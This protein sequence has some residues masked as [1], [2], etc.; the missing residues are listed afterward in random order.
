MTTSIL[1]FASHNMLLSSLAAS[2]ANFFKPAAA[3]AAPAAAEQG[4][5]SLYRMAASGDSVSP[6]VAAALA[7]RAQA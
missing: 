1:P 3:Q 6:A 7:K 2:V 4:L 5:M